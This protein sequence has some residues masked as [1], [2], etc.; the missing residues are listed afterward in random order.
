MA[1]TTP[2]TWVTGETV[3]AALLN[4]HLR[5]NLLDPSPTG[6]TSAVGGLRIGSGT[7]RMTAFLI[8]STTID[9]G[10]LS[11][12]NVVNISCTVTG[13]AA[14]DGVISVAMSAAASS[15][16]LKI[17]GQV[18]SAN[19]VTIRIFNGDSASIDLPNSTYTA[20]VL[21]AATS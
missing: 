2:R 5:D 12:G 6:I 13:A 4:A 15:D 17:D 19:T 20:Y 10:S 7:A 3:T 1:W 8:G 11:S 16:E 9:L 21:K 18:T 14:S